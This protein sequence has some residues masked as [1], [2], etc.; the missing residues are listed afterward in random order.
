[1]KI[2]KRTGPKSVIGHL[3]L[4][5]ND[6]FM[7][8]KKSIKKSRKGKP[9][10]WTGHMS[11]PNVFPSVSS[12]VRRSDTLPLRLMEETRSNNYRTYVP[13]WKTV[14]MREY[15]NFMSS[16]QPPPNFNRNLLSFTTEELN[17]SNGNY[18]KINT[19]RARER[20]RQ[21]AHRD[22]YRIYSTRWERRLE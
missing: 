7:Y 2:L 12:G 16:R 8:G 14:D 17:Q 15:S 21:K 6:T 22:I 4:S 5:D 11:T 19:A 20:R 1:M 3:G 18:A 10:K 13:S 9:S